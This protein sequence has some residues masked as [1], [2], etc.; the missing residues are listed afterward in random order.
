[1]SDEHRTQEY[2][3]LINQLLSSNEG[4]EL[5]LLQDNQG[6]LDQGLI[7]TMVAVAQQCK[8]KGRENEA[9]GLIN[10]AKELAE[11]L[12]A[13]GLLENEK[14]KTQIRFKTILIS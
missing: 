2:L 7:E 5:Q 12:E 4:N 6:L 8:D 3:H 9:Q 11:A 1:M 10:I 13:L 14:K